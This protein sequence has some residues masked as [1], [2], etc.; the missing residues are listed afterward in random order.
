MSAAARAV[1]WDALSD[2]TTHFV[3]LDYLAGTYRIQTRGHDGVTGQAAPLTQRTQTSD[4]AAVAN[5]IAHVIETSFSPVGT[6][7]AVG[8]DVTLNLRGGH[9][10]VPMDRWVQRGH[11]FAV[12]RIMEASG[13]QRASRIDWALLEALDAPVNGV[14]RCRY[15]QRY[16]ED[17][18]KDGAGTLLDQTMVLL[19]SNLGNASSHS[20]ENLPILLAGGGFK[21]GQHLPFSQTKNTPLA[22]L[23]VT[24]LQ[25]LGVETDRFAS[26]T[27]TL[28][29]LDMT[30]S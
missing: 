26:S 12:S 8:K 28:T 10:G 22:N 17:A 19:G 7:T 20:N 18:L 30:S 23:F 14:V 2:R 1:A 13:K 29:G 3:L 11:V 16:Q 5:A 9:L 15:R 27:G 21:H 25:R 24:M 4:R 6:V